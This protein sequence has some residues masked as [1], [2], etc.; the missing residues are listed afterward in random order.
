MR[1]SR[2]IAAIAAL[3]L[4]PASAVAA[5]PAH[6]EL[7]PLFAA[8]WWLRGHATL[9]DWSGK[10]SA[11]DGVDAIGAWRASTGDGVVVAVADSGVDL[12]TP[13]LAGQLLPGR[14]FLTGK[15]LIA[16]PLGHGTHVATLIAGNPQQSDGIFGVAPGARILPLRVA[17]VGG[18]VRARAAA[19]ALAYAARDSRVRVINMSWKKDFSPVLGRALSAAASTRSVLLVS[20]AGNDSRQLSGSRILPQ[21]L[22]SPNEITVAS[23]DILDSLSWFSNFGEHVEVAAPGERILSAFPAGTLK[24]DDG[25]SMAAPIVSGVAALLFSLHPEASAAQVK[26]AILSSCMPVPQLAGQVDCGGIVNAPAAL[27]MLAAILRQ[28]G[29]TP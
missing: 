19:A 4:L 27:E 10:A 8:E 5:P 21:T 14:D 18:H 25:T 15:P 11:S 3:A 2:L 24:I 28:S 7:N 17:T 29:A 6:P 16:D 26:Q 23:T 12:R 9:I 1:V 13:A 20:A 22:D